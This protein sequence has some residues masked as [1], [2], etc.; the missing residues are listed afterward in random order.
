M[1]PNWKTYQ[2][3]KIGYCSRFDAVK[4]SKAPYFLRPHYFALI[5]GIAYEAARFRVIRQMSDG[6]KVATNFVQSLALHR[7]KWWGICKT[8]L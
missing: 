6:I 5:M 7:C 3:S 2:N 4:K 1:P 8:L